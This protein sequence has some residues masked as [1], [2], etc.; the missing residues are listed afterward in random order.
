MEL[1]G[2]EN[3]WLRLSSGESLPKLHRGGLA[4]TNA[5]EVTAEGRADPLLPIGVSSSQRWIGRGPG[6]PGSQSFSS[7]ESSRQ[8]KGVRPSKGFSLSHCAWSAGGLNGLSPPIPG[9]PIRPSLPVL[10]PDGRLGVAAPPHSLPP[11]GREGDGDLPRA[12][13]S[14]GGQRGNPRLGG[15]AS[16]TPAPTA[17]RPRTWQRMGPPRR[18][19]TLRG[20]RGPKATSYTARAVCGGGSSTPGGGGGPAPWISPGAGRTQ[21]R[22]PPGLRQGGEREP[23]R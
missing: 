16:G 5:A 4:L 20:P 9:R 19:C 11:L 7:S 17:S 1:G 12:C 10:R 22:S 14:C 18:E 6:E 23:K 15:T 21:A 13:P 8:S 3:P 2:G